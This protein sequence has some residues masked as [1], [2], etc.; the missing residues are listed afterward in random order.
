MPRPKSWTAD[1]ARCAAAGIPDGTVF[2]TKPKLARVMIAKGHRYYDW[3]WVA[4][5]PPSARPPLAA[6]P[7]QPADQGAGVLPLLLTLPHPPRHP[8]QSRRAVVDDGG[9]LPGQ[10]ATDWAG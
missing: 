9:E 7:P 10:H 6:G 2:A 5:G 8:G 4:I 1:P 3:A